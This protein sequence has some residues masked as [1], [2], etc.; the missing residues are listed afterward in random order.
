MSLSVFA[1]ITALGDF[2]QAIR[3]HPSE[4][5]WLLF[6]VNS[7]S[8]QCVISLHPLRKVSLIEMRRSVRLVLVAKSTQPLKPHESTFKSPIQI[9]TTWSKR[10]QAGLFLS[11]FDLRAITITDALQSTQ[12]TTQPSSS[13]ATASTA[14]SRWLVAASPIVVSVSHLSFLNWEQM[15]GR[16][17]TANFIGNVDSARSVKVRGCFGLLA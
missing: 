9:P 12:T 17:Q 10:Y 6:D 3:K 7:S 8:T 4:G 14:L 16:Q 5:Y 2:I 15:D 11:D 13:L 1:L